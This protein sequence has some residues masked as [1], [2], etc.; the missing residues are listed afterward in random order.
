MKVY[1]VIEFS[2]NN[3]PRKI[4]GV[5]SSKNSAINCAYK[6]K[7]IFCTIIEKELDK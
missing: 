7:N 5:F 4:R 2:K 6:D 3:L 1:I